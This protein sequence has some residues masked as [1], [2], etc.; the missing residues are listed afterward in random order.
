MATHRFSA[1]VHAVDKLLRLQREHVARLLVD[2]RSKNPRLAELVQ[3]ARQTDVPIE[4]VRSHRLDDLA[5]GT[6]HQGVV[7]ELTGLEP[8]DEAGLRARVEAALTAGTA[9]LILILD[10]V[11]DPHNLGACLRSADA[12]GVLA[13]VTPRKAAAGLTPAARKV[14]SGAAEAVPVVAVASLVKVLDWLGNYGI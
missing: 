13:V 2:E 6:A 8:L 4:W 14:A 11:Q 7:A 5:A 12:A 1:G 9:P 3:R 10:G